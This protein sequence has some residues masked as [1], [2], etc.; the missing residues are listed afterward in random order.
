ME[1]S[2]LVSLKKNQNAPRLSDT[3]R[4]EPKSASKPA[5][6]RVQEEKGARPLG[7]VS[8][9]AT[10]GWRT[11]SW[12]FTPRSEQA[13]FF[14][15]L[16]VEETPNLC[17]TFGMAK[18]EE[19]VEKALM[20]PSSVAVTSV[21]SVN[22]NLATLMAPAGPLPGEVRESLSGGASTP[23]EAR[24]STKTS[25]PTPAPLPAT[26][27]RAT[28]RDNGIH[29]PNVVTRR[30]G[31]ELTDMDT[32]AR[33]VLPKTLNNNKDD[34]N[35]NNNNH[36]ALAERI[37]PRTLHKMRQLGRY[38]NTDTPDDNNI[39]NNHAALAERFQSRT[40]HTV[41]QLGRYTNTDTPDDN[42]NNNNH[43]ALVERFQPSTLHKVRQLGRYTNT[44]TPDTAHQ[45]DAE[46]VPVEVA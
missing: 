21:G 42:I 40:L 26:A 6:V 18:T 12:P 4:A 35:I 30:A 13:I 3:L 32:C 44:D 46:A 8:T 41:R 17:Y 7:P 20:A 38:T 5:N 31:M 29:R 33:G 11:C 10:E 25:R 9:A 14:R 36:A 24:A 43:A 23:T 27:R 45:L 2:P 19:Y 16:V 37:Q 39:N 34:N 1:N 28:M 15:G 22:S